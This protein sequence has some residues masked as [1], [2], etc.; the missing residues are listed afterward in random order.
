MSQ[1]L[2]SERRE[3]VLAGVE[4]ECSSLFSG[5]HELGISAAAVIVVSRRRDLLLHENAKHLPI[6]LCGK[7]RSD[8]DAVRGKKPPRDEERI[9]NVEL[10]CIQE[11]V[12]VL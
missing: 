4:M 6:G 10:Q 1:F 7:L 12:R 5:A 2:G 8:V 9:Q 11:I 3:V